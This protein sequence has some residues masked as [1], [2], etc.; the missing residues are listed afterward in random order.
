MSFQTISLDSATKK[1][2]PSELHLEDGNQATVDN[3]FSTI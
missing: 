2:V 3:I 1:K